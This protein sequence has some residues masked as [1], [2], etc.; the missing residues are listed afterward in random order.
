MSPV[1]TEN[2]RRLKPLKGNDRR[3]LETVLE[4]E[5]ADKNVR[6]LALDWDEDEAHFAF[7]ISIFTPSLSDGI[8]DLRASVLEA[9]ADS[10]KSAARR[11]ICLIRETIG[12]NRFR[13]MG[14]YTAKI[15]KRQD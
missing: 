8:R 1:A 15:M 7:L 2:P 14:A 10:E 9:G 12:P 13:R 3:K 11:A 4:E 6:R 5:G